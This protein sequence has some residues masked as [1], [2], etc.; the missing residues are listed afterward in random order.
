YAICDRRA[1]RL[2]DAAEFQRLED[3]PPTKRRRSQAQS[4][5]SR[6]RAAAKGGIIACTKASFVWVLS[7]LVSG[8]ASLHCGWR[9]YSVCLPPSSPVPPSPLYHGLRFCRR[10]A[11][12]GFDS[13]VRLI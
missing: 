8:L 10:S 5:L 11:M 13:A 6:L 7:F 3:S 4:A 2:S 12:T 9:E 1:R